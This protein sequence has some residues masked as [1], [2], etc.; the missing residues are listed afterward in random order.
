MRSEAN[1]DGGFAAPVFDAQATFRL[2]MD[3]MARPARSMA[4]TPLANP[5]AGLA[6]LAGAMACALT[7]A[8]T[9]VWLD[10]VLRS[11]A[12]DA[13]IAFHTGAPRAEAPVDAMF[14]LVGDPRSMPPLD[15]FSQGSQDYP[16]RSA[17]LLLQVTSLEGG[18]P[19]TFGGP[20][21]RGRETIAPQGLPADFAAQ[22]RANSARFPRGVD[23]ILVADG[24]IAGLP[25]SARLVETET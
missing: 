11:D 13:W 7:D 17:T 19:L 14:A 10:P 25:R 8:D 23:L 12:L 5:P 15:R 16:D 2:V 1:L 6:P 9:P 20:G 4:A 21:I 22:W 24:E 18:V 3:A